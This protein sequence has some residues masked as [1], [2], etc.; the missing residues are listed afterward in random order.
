MIGRR[1]EVKGGMLAAAEGTV[2][3]M[4]WLIDYNA[5]NST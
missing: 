4:D 3:M 5:S 2:L 1:G